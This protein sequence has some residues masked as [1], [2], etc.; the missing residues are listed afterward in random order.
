[1]LHRSNRARLPE[2]L[3][4]VLGLTAAWTLLTVGL[5]VPVL[6]DLTG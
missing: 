3:P 2:E 4:R 6:E 1:M 5:L